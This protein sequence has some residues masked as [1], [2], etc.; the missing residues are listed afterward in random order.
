M[1]LPLPKDRFVAA[2]TFE[3]AESPECKRKREQKREAGGKVK[4]VEGSCEG[5]VC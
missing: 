3:M 2:E 4:R 5:T 1:T